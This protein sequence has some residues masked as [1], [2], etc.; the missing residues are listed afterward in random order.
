MRVKLPAF[1]FLI[2]F[3]CSLFLIFPQ[4]L[5]A[6]V[7]INEISP[8]SSPE[9]VK[10]YND[11]LDSVSLDG[12]IIYFSSSTD[13]SQKR[14]FCS[15]Q[16]I[17]P[18]SFL[19]IEVSR[20]L[21]NSGDSVLLEDNGKIIDS[22]S[23]GSGKTLPKL[24]GSQSGKRDPDGSENWIVV[25][26]PIEDGE[27]VSFSCLTPTP[28]LT[29]VP[30]P[31]FTPTLTPTPIQSS[32]TYTINKAMDESGN[33]LS[34]V[35]IYIDGQYTG[36]YAEETYTFCDGCK[37]G[38]N[39]VDCGFGS[40]IFKLEKN[41]YR[42]WTKME[43]IN[44]GDSLEVDP[45]LEKEVIDTPTPTPTASKNPIPTVKLIKS[46]TPSINDNENGSSEEMVLGLRNELKEKNSNS[47][48]EEEKIKEIRKKKSPVF[49]GILIFLGL[50]SLGY[51]G[52]YLYRK[53]KVKYKNGENG[54]EIKAGK[55]EE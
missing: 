53:N 5:F 48:D 2:Y 18:Y 19:V 17:S 1:I 27:I 51:S 50:S 24:S 32:A 14:I 30:T 31:V 16:S 11:S 36:N 25:D 6:K 12:Y 44:L 39:K 23:Y 41:G 8:A 40:H 46:G 10:I 38:S 3:L 34:K 35:R 52:F 26:D 21:N 54:K 13:T 33:S 43:T 29:P 7:V 37:C 9:W 45:V 20:Y 49:G 28:I 15:S 42:D 55:D 47:N 22:I 4:I